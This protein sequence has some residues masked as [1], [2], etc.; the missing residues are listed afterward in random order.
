M[1]PI[2]RKNIEKNES[3]KAIK[4]ESGKENIELLDDKTPEEK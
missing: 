3:N 1:D 2:K 4:T